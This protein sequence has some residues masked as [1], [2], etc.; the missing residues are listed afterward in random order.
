MKKT[1]L[2]LIIFCCLFIFT[3]CRLQYDDRSAR[4]SLNSFLNALQNGDKAALYYVA[5][6]YNTDIQFVG[7][8]KEDLEMA[9][10]GKGSGSRLELLLGEATFEIPKLTKSQEKQLK[11]DHF[12][13]VTVKANVQH[14]DEYLPY[15]AVKYILEND[16]GFL[17]NDLREPENLVEFYGKLQ[18]NIPSFEETFDIQI[19]ENNEGGYSF[20]CQDL[21]KTLH[22]D[23]AYRMSQKGGLQFSLYPYHIDAV[24]EN[25]L[26]QKQ[27]VVL[28]ALNHAKNMI[29]NQTF[30]L[31]LIFNDLKE[32]IKNPNVHTLMQWFDQ[33][34]EQKKEEINLAYRQEGNF[35]YLT[36]GQYDPFT[37][38][39]EHSMI[40]YLINGKS[41]Y[42]T[43]ITILD[44]IDHVFDLCQ[45]YKNE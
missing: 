33:L 14:W 13:T 27:F 30:N 39:H 1:K 20:A 41:Y 45:T 5:H 11:N 18:D 15:V 37:Y 7:T 35:N 25:Q 43:E 4:S 12:T 23:S 6:P 19:I 42:G 31:S 34:D 32:V 29:E 21:L 2:V 38:K 22:I 28:N 44:E 17:A 10:Q 16:I 36:Y 24:E 40:V 8:L 9:F 3:G 26:G